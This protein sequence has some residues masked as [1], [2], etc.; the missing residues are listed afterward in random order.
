MAKNLCLNVGDKA[1]N[2]T[3]KDHNDMN[4][5][6]IDFK[7]KKILLSFH[8]LAWTSVCAKQM[9]SLESNQNFFKEYN[10]VAVGLSV[11]SVPSKKAW[12]KSLNISKTRLLSDF[13]PHGNVAKM[14]GIFREKDGISERVNIIINEEQKIESIF[15][16]ELSELPDI[17]EIKSY[18]KTMKSFEE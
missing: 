10:T 4:F 3:L 15:L 5:S 12:A 2:F 1:P 11:D 13:W 9:E 17:N 14:F 6:L 16:Y 7:G 18:I 8:P